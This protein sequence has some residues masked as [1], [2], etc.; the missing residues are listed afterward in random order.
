MARNPYRLVKRRTPTPTHHHAPPW[1]NRLPWSLS[2]CVAL[3]AGYYT[4]RRRDGRRAQGD[5]VARLRAC[6]AYDD[7]QLDLDPTLEQR[8]RELEADPGRLGL[9]S[10]DP[11]VM[12]AICALQV[13]TVLAKHGFPVTNQADVA[14]CPVRF[15]SSLV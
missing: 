3:G 9:Y 8:L 6:A 14:T 15:C 10:A 2:A 11:R 13:S 5:V 12:Q 1:S 7:R 4:R